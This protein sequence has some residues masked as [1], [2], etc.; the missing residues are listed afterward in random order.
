LHAS[1]PMERVRIVRHS[2]G[3]VQF[4]K[5]LLPASV[6][7]AEVTAVFQCMAVDCLERGMRGALLVDNDRPA[8]GEAD[9]KA[10]VSVLDLS[11]C[12]V[13]FRLAVVAFR[14]PAY[15]A[16]LTALASLPR[17]ALHTALFWDELDAM[18]WLRQQFPE[19]SLSSR[20][21]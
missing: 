10:A 13:N 1:F 6:T 8:M 17:S 5:F 11:R 4:M 20:S 16:Y 9:L 2:I 12:P 15:R 21:T 7:P 18:A 3:P 19:E 14:K